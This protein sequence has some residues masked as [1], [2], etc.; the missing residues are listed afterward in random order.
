MLFATAAPTTIKNLM[1][2]YALLYANKQTPNYLLEIM[3]QTYAGLHPQTEPGMVF[4]DDRAPVEQ[5]TNSMV[6]NFLLAG[7]VD[8][9]R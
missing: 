4:T 8:S 1:D 3:A 7:K 5:I 6:L 2:N 9:L